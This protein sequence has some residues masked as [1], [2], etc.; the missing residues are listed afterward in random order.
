MPK[1]LT[2]AF[3]TLILGCRGRDR[4]RPPPFTLIW[5]KQGR[6]YTGPAD[7]LCTTMVSASMNL[8]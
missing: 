2:T 7:R 6:L 5:Y 1:N 3:S 4:G 8:S